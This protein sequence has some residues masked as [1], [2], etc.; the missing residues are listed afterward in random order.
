MM[1]IYMGNIIY[2]LFIL[3]GLYIIIIIIELILSYNDYRFRN[4]T[5]PSH[6]HCVINSVRQS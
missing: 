1:G 4:E 2:F 6:L 3:F 5:I